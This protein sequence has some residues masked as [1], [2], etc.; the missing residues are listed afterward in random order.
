L[1]LLQDVFGAHV[2]INFRCREM[3]VPED[4]LKGACGSD[5]VDPQNRERVPEHVGSEGLRNAGFVRDALH[6][7]LDR[8]RAPRKF[9]VHYEKVL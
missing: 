3:I 9:I 5:F 8:P 4:L 1:E 2:Q 7:A 6:Y